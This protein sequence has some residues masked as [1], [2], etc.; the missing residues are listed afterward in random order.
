MKTIVV[1][2]LIFGCFAV[3]Y[4]RL[5]YPV[6]VSFIGSKSRIPNADFDPSSGSFG[7]FGLCCFVIEM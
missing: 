4:P 1:F 3:L 6:L 5:F 2:V 7:M